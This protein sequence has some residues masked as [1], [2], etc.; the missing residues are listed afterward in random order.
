MEKFRSLITSIT[1]IDDTD[2]NRK[3]KLFGFAFL[4]IVLGLVAISLFMIGEWSIE[5]LIA[6]TIAA[7]RPEILTQPPISWVRTLSLWGVAIF[8]TVHVIGEIVMLI[9]RLI[10]SRNSNEQ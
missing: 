10:P 9:V 8:W 7:E 5:K 6:L 1:H 3:V 2:V 4:R